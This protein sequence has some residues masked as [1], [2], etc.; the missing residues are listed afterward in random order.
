MRLIPK[1]GRERKPEKGRK[2]FPSIDFQKIIQIRN[3]RRGEKAKFCSQKWVQ[4][5][6]CRCW[7]DA[8]DEDETDTLRKEE[9]N[10][11]E[12]KKGIFRP[13]NLGQTSQKRLQEV[14]TQRRKKYLF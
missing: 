11:K 7:K 5:A 6:S 10:I 13:V 14:R 1:M 12:V 3:Q 9:I 2:Y 4:W 8:P